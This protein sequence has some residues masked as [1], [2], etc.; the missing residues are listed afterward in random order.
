MVDERAKKEEKSRKIEGQ[1]GKKHAGSVLR[2]WSARTPRQS[3]EEYP[4][5][6]RFEPNVG[7]RATPERRIST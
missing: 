5:G 1:Q 4:S 2:L 6:L 7:Q 3:Q